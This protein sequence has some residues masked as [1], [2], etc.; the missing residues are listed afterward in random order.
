VLLE[1]DALTKHFG[2]EAAV[3][4]VTLRVGE[5]QI[6]ALVGPN[7]AGKSTLLKMIAGLERPTSGTVRVGA[8]SVHGLSPHQ[9]RHQGVAIVMQTP[10]TFTS[11]TV[12]ENAT[13]GAMFGAG[14]GV[15]PERE[16]RDRAAK[17]LAFVGL[18]NRVGDPVG[19]LNLHQQRFLELGKALSGQPRLLLLDEVMAG[20]N[21]TEI[22]ASVQ[23]VRNVRDELGIT[24]LW[25][26]HVMSAVMELAE[27]VIVLNFGSILTEGAPEAVMRHPEVVEAYLGEAQIA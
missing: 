14:H 25:V 15:V 16:A 22:S 4:G 5:G 11:M 26:E 18:G 8:K 27:R 6:V 3:E 17:S 21:E 13:L 23:I 10:L 9:A 12:L 2:G 7:G 24:I 19:S 1:V 20:L